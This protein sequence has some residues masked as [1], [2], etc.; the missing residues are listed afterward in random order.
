MSLRTRGQDRS[1][2]HGRAEALPA[3]AG[4]DA[5]GVVYAD[6]DV[7]DGERPVDEAREARAELAMYDCEV[8]FADVVLLELLGE[9]L[10]G[11][12]RLCEDETARDGLRGGG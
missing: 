12:G 11:W 1:E 2:T 10:C 4:C 9:A 8:L 7:A 5:F 6:A 3:G